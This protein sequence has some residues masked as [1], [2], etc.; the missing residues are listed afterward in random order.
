MFKY[1]KYLIKAGDSFHP[2]SFPGIEA[3]VENVFASLS[4][5]EADFKAE[6]LIAYLNKENFD[7]SSVAANPRLARKIA[8]G[9]LEL[10]EIQSLFESCQEHP[11]FKK[12]LEAYITNR[13]EPSYALKGN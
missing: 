12:E 5:Q 2:S 11:D 7:T 3:N 4:L 9:E 13:F 8:S 10:A 6:M 1:Q